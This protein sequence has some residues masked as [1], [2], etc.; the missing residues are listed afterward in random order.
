[1]LLT[2]EGRMDELPSAVVVVLA[3]ENKEIHVW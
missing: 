2:A 3:R 1:L